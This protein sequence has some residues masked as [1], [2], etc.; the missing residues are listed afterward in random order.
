[1]P[2]AIREISEFEVRSADELWLAS[3]T[4]ELLPITTLD[5]MPVGTGR[6]GPVYGRLDALYRDYKESVMR[7]GA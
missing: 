2:H 6:P 3:S 4:R 5:G 1:V 7:G